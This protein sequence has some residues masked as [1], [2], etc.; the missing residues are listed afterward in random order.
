MKEQIT[1]VKRRKYDA[2][3]KQEVL[4]MIVNGRSAKSVVES[5]TRRTLT[6]TLL[7]YCS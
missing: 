5:F 6:N 2:T 3:F 1:K 7:F 4:Q